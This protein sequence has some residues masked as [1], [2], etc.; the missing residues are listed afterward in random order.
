MLTLT[1]M[2]IFSQVG[3][4]TTT[5]NNSSVL[6]VFSSNKGVLFPRVSLQSVTD[7]T[8]VLNPAEGLL[9]WNT[10][11]GLV[12]GKGF[13]YFLDG[14]WVQIPK[15]FNSTGK[16]YEFVEF[17]QTSSSINMTSSLQELTQLNTTYT[18]LANGNLFLNYTIYATM[19]NSDP[20]VSNVFCEIQVTDNTNSTL[21][22]GTLLVSPVNVINNQGSNAVASP[23]VIPISIINGH[24]YTIKIFAKEAYLDTS[25]YTVRVGTVNYTG[26]FANSSLIINSLLNNN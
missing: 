17:K 9:V 8:T 4:N 3:I 12:Q 21:Q 19:N 6:D 2:L 18:A 22:K 14:K 10:N 25:I 5:P 23:S 15:Q 13:F 24:N 1:P 16:T 20:R 7:V 26:S 11:N